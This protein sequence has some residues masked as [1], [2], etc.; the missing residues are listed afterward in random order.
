LPILAQGSV[1]ISS[2]LHRN[3]WIGNMSPKWSVED[4]CYGQEIEER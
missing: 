2:M 4:H 1:V 3:V